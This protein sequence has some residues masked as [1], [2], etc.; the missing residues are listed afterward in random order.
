MLYLPAAWPL[1]PCRISFFAYLLILLAL[2]LIFWGVTTAIP[3][4]SLLH[5]EPQLARG[6]HTADTPSIIVCGTS[7]V[8]QWLR[9]HASNAESLGSIP[10]QGTRSHMLQLRP[11]VNKQ[12]N[13]I[14]KKKTNNLWIE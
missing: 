4:L 3:S 10:G 9:L 5:S 13:K 6:Q 14:L 1:L 8:V 12:I 11:S 2:C 7:L